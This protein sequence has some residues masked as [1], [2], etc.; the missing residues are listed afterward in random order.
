MSGTVTDPSAIVRVFELEE[1]EGDG[2]FK[3][4]MEGKLIGEPEIPPDGTFEIMLRPGH[5]VVKVFAADD[6]L[7]EQRKVKVK[8]NKMIHLAF[9]LSLK[10]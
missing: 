1:R 5:Y 10:D 7:L 8:R 3:L 9:D 2:T 4:F 6:E